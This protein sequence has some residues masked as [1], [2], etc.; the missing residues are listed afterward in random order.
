ML[1]TGLAPSDEREAAFVTTL[2]P[3]AYTVGVTGLNGGTGVGLLEIYDVDLASPARLANLS[4]RGFVG[5][6]NDLMIG[7]FIVRGNEAEARLV[8][9]GVGPSLTAA[10][11]TEPLDDPTLEVRDSQGALVAAN[12][13]WRSAQEAEIIASTLAPLHEKEAAVVL[14]LPPGPYTAL[15]R[16]S[17][18]GTGIGLLEAYRLQ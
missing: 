17:R 11:I 18:G 4:S 15:L 10:A 3:G 1:A 12:D 5:S 16:G 13:D 2:L 8:V 7:G 6:G 9:R 14:Q